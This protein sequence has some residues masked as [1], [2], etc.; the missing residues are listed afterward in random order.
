MLVAHAGRPLLCG[1]ADRAG[2]R[3]VRRAAG[4]LAVVVGQQ[5]AQL[6]DGAAQ[7][8]RGS[9]RRGAFQH[10]AERTLIGQGGGDAQAQRVAR[11]GPQ[12]HTPAGAAGEVMPAGEAEPRL[13][14]RGQ[15]VDPRGR[16]LEL[17]EMREVELDRLLGNQPQQAADAFAAVLRDETQDVVLEARH[18]LALPTRPGRSGMISVMSAPK[19]ARNSLAI[20]AV[21]V[22]QQVNQKRACLVGDVDRVA[23]VLGRTVGPGVVLRVLQGER[24]AVEDHRAR[25]ASEAEAR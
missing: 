10:Q 23:F 6:A 15:A 16:E 4:A 12:E 18:P 11:R 2:C 1:L 3:P 8:V 5:A 17:V 7:V 20:D 24:R 9:P 13:E 14:V 25:R 19:I 21:G 22:A